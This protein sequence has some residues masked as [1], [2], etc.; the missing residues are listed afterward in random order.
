M[1]PHGYQNPD[2]PAQRVTAALSDCPFVSTCAFLSN[3]TDLNFPDEVSLNFAMPWFSPT[4][5]Q[6]AFTPEGI[7]PY[8]T[9]ILS[10]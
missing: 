1:S 6:P 10:M 3:N 8:I 4:L 7:C 9:S 2:H 5:L